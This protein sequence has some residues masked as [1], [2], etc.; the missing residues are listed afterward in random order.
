MTV[1]LVEECYDSLQ[2][3]W[4][5]TKE[6]VDGGSCMEEVGKFAIVLSSYGVIHFY[7]NIL[8]MFK[9]LFFYLVNEFSMLQI[10]GLNFVQTIPLL[11]MITLI[12]FTG[13]GEGS[14]SVT[15]VLNWA[16]FVSVLFIWVP[17]GEI[18]FSQGKEMNRR[19]EFVQWKRHM[20]EVAELTDAMNL[21]K[22]EVNDMREKVQ[23]TDA[24]IRMVESQLKEME[25][26]QES[27]KVNV[28]EELIFGR[29]L[30]EGSY[31]AVYQA[32]YRGQKAA[33]KQVLSS[34]MDDH[35][36]AKFKEEVMLLTTLHHPN[37]I[38][39]LGASW[40]LPHIALVMEFA[41][42]GGERA[43]SEASRRERSEP[44]YE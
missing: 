36:L 11:V 32:T 4:N 30:G 21:A 35:H 22:R 44:T 25:M 42:N 5:A 39:L 6:I 27:I 18:K 24:Q 3:K 31:G 20:A 10:V 38:L 14:F 26:G 29:L 9:G 40:T 12:H 37:V 43:A 15:M 7:S 33:V 34:N 17:W 1:D 8:I 41:G 13:F 28:D 16:M 2:N 23:F 19:R